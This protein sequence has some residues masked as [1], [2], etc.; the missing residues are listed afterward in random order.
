MKST[1]RPITIAILTC[2]LALPLSACGSDSS[3][4]ESG[5]D[6]TST[7]TESESAEADNPAPPAENLL[8]SMSADE[9]EAKLQT[10]S[11]N[12]QPLTIPTPHQELT[13]M[14]QMMGGAFEEVVNSMTVEPADC[15]KW[16]Q[17]AQK[18]QQLADIEF[19]VA[20]NTADN[21]ITV[22]VE[23]TTSDVSQS[24]D[25]LLAY[26]S[27]CP[28]ISLEI[29]SMGIDSQISQTAT[30]AVIDPFPKGVILTQNQIISEMTVNVH[31]YYGVD[32]AN[33]L[34]VMV[35]GP[36]SSP[37]TDDFEAVVTDIISQLNTQ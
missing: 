34:F 12:G 9:I 13:D 36:A 27:E 30:S 35:G 11:I 24:V 25:D 22:L 6:T 33:G 4:P 20:G 17:D 14:S 18:I 37:S 32:P 7:A 31:S 28:D 23:K 5:T 26:A 15:L 21:D 3:A 10:V 29:P 16:A 2:S 19:A 1:L 8:G